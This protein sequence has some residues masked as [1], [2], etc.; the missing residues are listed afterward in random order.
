[1]K[2]L[3]IRNID[4]M[5]LEEEEELKTTLINLNIDFDIGECKNDTRTQKNKMQ[6]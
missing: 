6:R 3:I 4:M 1:M 2:C 5:T